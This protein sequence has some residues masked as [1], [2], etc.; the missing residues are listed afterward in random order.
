MQRIN[1]TQLAVINSVGMKELPCFELVAQ[2]K[3]I[4]A[5]MLNNPQPMGLNKSVVHQLKSKWGSKLTQQQIQ[6][7]RQEKKAR[8]KQAK[9]NKVRNYI[10]ILINILEDY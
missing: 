7:E 2:Q 1:R 10:L 5:E 6:K 8:I 9:K 4:V 3:E